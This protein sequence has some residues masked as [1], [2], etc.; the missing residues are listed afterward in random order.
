MVRKSGGAIVVVTVLVVVGCLLMFRRPP[1]SN[2][3]PQ[4]RTEFAAD[5]PQTAS[6][7]GKKALAHLEEI[8]KIGPRISGTEGMKKQQEML[9]KH[10]EDL[11]AKVEFQKFSVR[12]VSRRAA[13]EMANMIVTWHP[14]KDRRVILCSHYDTR[15][16]ADQEPERAD[17]HKPFVSANDGGSGVALLMELGRHM[18]DLKTNV[19]VD[20]VFFDGEEYVFN[21]SREGDG[22]KYFLGSEHFADTYKRTRPKH[23]YIAGILLDMVG[24][25]NAQFLAEQNSYFLAGRLVEEVWQAAQEVRSPLFVKEMGPFRVEDDHL[26][27][28]RVGIPTI[29]IIDY[30]Y[31]QGPHWHRLTDVP[32]NCS[33]D[34]FAE[35]GRV[36][37]YWLQRVK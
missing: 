25:K 31:M 19:G 30:G 16:I 33:A 7:D 37:A 35:L 15:P 2:A 32:E 20:F 21:P 14:D 12:Q 5:A 11:G 18:K 13:V 9:K 24:G 8:C 17:W 28:N 3:E 1:E 4:R 6:V 34:T 27:L 36:L 23:R 29:D 22:D 10:F 26:A